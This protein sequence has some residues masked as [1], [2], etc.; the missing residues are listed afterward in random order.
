MPLL[1]C[2][3]PG[4]SGHLLRT[5]H[6][7]G[8]IQQSGRAGAGGGPVRTTLACRSSFPNPNTPQCP[9]THSSSWVLAG[10]KSAC[11]SRP[12]HLLDKAGPHRALISGHGLTLQKNRD[13]ERFRIVAKRQSGDLNLALC[14]ACSVLHTPLTQ[15]QVPLSAPRRGLQQTP[16]PLTPTPKAAGE[17]E[18]PHCCGP[19]S[20]PVPSA[21]KQRA[22]RPVPGGWAGVTDSRWLPH[23]WV[24][25]SGLTSQERRVPAPERGTP[26]QRPPE[27]WGSSL[28]PWRGWTALGSRPPSAPIHTTGESCRS[29][30]VGTSSTWQSRR[31]RDARCPLSPERHL[32][33]DSGHDRTCQRPWAKT[34]R[35]QLAGSTT[36]GQ[37]VAWRELNTRAPAVTPVLP[38][39]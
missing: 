35:E 5:E 1:A 30:E 33:L 38:L 37:G 32:A 25:A 4:S 13:H 20:Q 15:A 22:Q 11:S 6:W 31:Y 34:T 8:R 2:A 14:K 28:L 39:H 23:L 17:A 19:G 27:G 10:A 12:G 26:L 9:A 3:R 7:E 18:C 24:S 16:M 36:A 21:T 29:K